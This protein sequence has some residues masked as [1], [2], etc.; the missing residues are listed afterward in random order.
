MMDNHKLSMSDI[1]YQDYD[2]ANIE[3]EVINWGDYGHKHVSKREL[4]TSQFL[5]VVCKYN[6]C[7]H[8]VY[9]GSNSCIIYGRRDDIE[10]IKVLLA[11][12]IPVCIR[13]EGRAYH[14]KYHDVHDNNPREY[15]KPMLKG[16]R[17]SWK[18]GFI[19][20]VLEA[21]EEQ[22]KASEAKAIA[23]G[24]QY[25]LVRLNGAI[26]AVDSYI[27]ANC[28]KGRKVSSSSGKRNDDGYNRGYREGKAAV[29][30]NQVEG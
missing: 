6:S 30:R 14:V 16:F 18:L 4:W 15:W 13:L 1:A 26:K 9:V 20:G 2:K 8:R 10:A 7:R 22:S 19:S 11:V 28:N 12:L 29:N 3:T 17:L 21:L 27:V 25:A 23:T 24:G 5:G